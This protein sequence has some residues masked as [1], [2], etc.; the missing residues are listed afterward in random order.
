MPSTAAH[1]TLGVQHRD[2]AC[3]C[4]WRRAL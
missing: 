2:I 1:C 3:K 4:R